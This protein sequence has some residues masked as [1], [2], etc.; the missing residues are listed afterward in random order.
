MENQLVIGSLERNDLAKKRV[1]LTE[2]NGS[3]DCKRRRKH[4]ECIFS[5]DRRGLLTLALKS[6]LSP[7]HTFNY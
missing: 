1:A 5:E 6:G 7:F 4:C 3:E 2:I